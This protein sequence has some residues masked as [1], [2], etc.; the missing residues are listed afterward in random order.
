[1]YLRNS[2]LAQ[3]QVV[4]RCDYNVP[5]QDGIIQ[6]TKRIDASLPTLHYIL[7]QPIQR[8]VIISHLGRPKG[9]DNR[10]SLQPV[11][12]YLETILQTKICLTTLNKFHTVS[13]E[14]II[15]LENIRFYPEEEP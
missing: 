11:K 10:L 9:I 4:L 14:S 5:L 7:K 13:H 1:M 12:D 3:K 2:Q 6:S 15:V 8:L